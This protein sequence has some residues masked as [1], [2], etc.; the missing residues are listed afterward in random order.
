MGCSLESAGQQKSAARACSAETSCCPGQCVLRPPCHRRAVGQSPKTLQL[1]TE[2]HYQNIIIIIII[3]T[4]VWMISWYMNVCAL[5]ATEWKIDT[6][7]CLKKKKNSFE[8]DDKKT[9]KIRAETIIQFI[10][11]SNICGFSHTKQKCE[12]ITFDSLQTGLSTCL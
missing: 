1:R 9:L 6:H 3:I 7:L 4:P 12:D 10:Q 11:K 2:E 5:W 8:L